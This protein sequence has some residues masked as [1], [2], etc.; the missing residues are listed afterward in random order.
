MSRHALLCRSLYLALAVGRTVAEAFA[1]GQAAVRAAPNIPESHREGGKF[2][3]LPADGN[4]DVA[5]FP[6]RP[7]LPAWPS[8]AM[9]LAAE[10][11]A[12]PRG[13][14]ASA[15]ELFDDGGQ[16]FDSLVGWLPSIPDDFCGRNAFMYVGGDAVC[17]SVRSA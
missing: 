8:P 17:H 5:I 9:R 10:R 16:G 13:S 15:Q 7:E 4:H 11:A 1:I 3:L 2:L 12:A 14:T 6:G